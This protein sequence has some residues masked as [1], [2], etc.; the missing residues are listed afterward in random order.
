[1]QAFKTTD[2][3][4]F[5]VEAD[6]TGLVNLI[7]NP[8]GELGGWGWVTPVVSG[9]L[10]GRKDAFGPYLE[11]RVQESEA[12][13]FFAE[14]RPV[15]AG[16]YVALRWTTHGGNGGVRVRFDWLDASRALLSSTAQSSYFNAATNVAFGP[17]QA[18]ASTAWVRVR[19]DYYANSSGGVPAFGSSYDF[20]EVTLAAASTAGELAGLGYIAPVSYTNV[21]GYAH[22]IRIPREQLNVGTLSA[23]ILSATLDPSQST[24]IR[25]G[26]RARLTSL[27]AGVWEPLI[28]GKLLE[29]DVTYELKD[30]KVPDEKRA[31]IKVTV[32]DPAQTLANTSRPEGVAHISS[33]PQVLEGAGVP[34][35]VNG[36]GDQVL[37]QE[38][39]TYNE[40]ANA[41]DQIALTRDTE[42]GYAW[43]SRTGVLNV[44]DRSSIP[45]TSVLL[46][47]AAYSDLDLSFSTA[48][49]VNEVVVVVQSLGTDGTTVETTY[50][51]YRDAASI[52]QWGTFRKTFT[53]TG[54]DSAGVDTYAADVLAAAATPRI[55]VNAITIPLDTV[56]RVEAYA[57]LDLYDAVQVVLTDRGIDDTLRVTGL[58]HT[59]GLNKWML[60]L[61]FSDEAGVAQPTKQPPVQ[62]GARPDVGVIE[63]FAGPT[64]AIPETKLRCDGTSYPVADYPHLFAVIGYTFGGSGAFFNV[65]D[66]VDRFP[67]GAGTKALGTTGGAGSTVLTAANLPPH[68]HTINHGH[69]VPMQYSPDV[70]TTGSGVRIIRINGEGAGGSGGTSSPFSVPT[71]TGNSGN[72]NG[73]TNPPTAVDVLNPWLSIHYVIRAA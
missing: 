33:L 71:F 70:P 15:S 5:E 52:A 36:S 13:W 24:L 39:T 59:I 34:W 7:Q 20:K 43:M 30:P 60:T 18:P 63:L 61:K 4:R 41:L 2:L 55:R 8:N 23:E 35:N 25:P 66:L 47:E 46:D 65:P 10:Q 67:I 32:T 9:F 58:E 3:V 48:D 12:Q 16:Q 54:L 22:E 29:A 37:A 64:S 28:S 42:L 68:A 73:L 31:R 50:G 45:T 14:D 17:H 69:S 51:P 49:C 62:S 6:P 19:V 56:A 40:G 21:I 44:W 26:R 72:G 53:V 11:Y 1:M 27:V 38:V 57:L